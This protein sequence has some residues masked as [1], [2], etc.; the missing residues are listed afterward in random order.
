VTWRAARHVGPQPPIGAPTNADV[1]GLT[2][3]PIFSFSVRAFFFWYFSGSVLF[4]YLFIY[5]IP[6]CRRQ[7]SISLPFCFSAILVFLLFISPPFF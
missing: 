6:S 4:I 2:C 5:S 3:P 7:F 1:A